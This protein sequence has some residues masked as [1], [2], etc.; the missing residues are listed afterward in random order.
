MMIM[1]KRSPIL[2]HALESL[3]HGLDHYIVGNEKDRKFCIL[4][5]DQAVELLLKEKIASQGKDLYKTDGQTLNFHESL[6]SLKDIP[7]PESTRLQEMHD[8]RNTIQHRGYTPDEISTGFYVEIAYSFIKRF[9]KDEFDITI[10][11]EVEKR[12][13]PMIEGA[14]QETVGELQKSIQGSLEK[15]DFTEAVIN[16]HV[17]L[18]NFTKD[19]EQSPQAK[20]RTTLRKM[21]LKNNDSIDTEA[22][23]QQLDTILSIRNQV[24]HKGTIPD[25]K[26][27]EHYR[28]AVLDILSKINPHNLE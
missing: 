2:R 26:I 17:L 24:V 8:V 11:D 5:I 27:I 10:E 18:Q 4:H 7:I 9:L 6:K 19:F 21:A 25:S 12:K 1:K 22:F 14:P 13:I 15:E 16:I 23:N 3:D 20:F 28:K